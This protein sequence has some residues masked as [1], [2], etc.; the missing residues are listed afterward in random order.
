MTIIAV[1]GRLQSGKDT[2]ANYLI[3]EYGF[4]RYSFAEPIKQ[5]CCLIFGWT[6]ESMEDPVLKEQIDPRWG[7]TRRQALQTMGTEWGQYDLMKISPTFA[8]VTGRK[9]WARSCLERVRAEQ[10]D[11]ARIVI[12][13]LRFPHEAEELRTNNANL[14]RVVRGAAPDIHSSHPS[15][16]EVCQVEV[17]RT[18]DNNESLYDLFNTIDGEMFRL[19]ILEL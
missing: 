14:W 13:D 19:N 12:S 3:R 17:D 8:S 5:A 9:L 15:E 6:R 2:V 10:N 7:I 18:L 1:S 16:A 4:I 11:N